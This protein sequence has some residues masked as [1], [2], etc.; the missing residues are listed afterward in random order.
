[1]LKIDKSFK[2]LI[3]KKKAF[4]RSNSYLDLEKDESSHNDSETNVGF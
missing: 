1:M 3:N 4:P 2:T